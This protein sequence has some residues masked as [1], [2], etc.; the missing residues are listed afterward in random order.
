M[1]E[2]EDGA[3]EMSDASEHMHAVVNAFIDELRMELSCTCQPDVAI[4]WHQLGAEHHEGHY[5]VMAQH[6]PWC[7]RAERKQQ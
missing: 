4:H 5:H 6:D 1:A 7:L 3:P 2:H